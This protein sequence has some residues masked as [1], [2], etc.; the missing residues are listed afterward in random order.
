M[1]QVLAG[2]CGLPGSIEC[3]GLITG[4]DHVCHAKQEV[5]GYRPQY[6]VD[7]ARRQPAIGVGQYLLQKAERV[8][9]RSVGVH[10]HDVQGLVLDPD[11][12]GLADV[13][14]P[15]SDVRDR[16]TA[17]IELLASR[18]DR[19]RDVVRLG[20]GKDEDRMRGRLLQCLEESIL[21]IAG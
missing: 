2:F 9:V 14:Q 10:G 18:P 5:L 11:A 13:L 17:E 1:A 4:R 15:R 6:R 12:L 8:P 3:S 7:V 19:N 20:S 21:S 16:A